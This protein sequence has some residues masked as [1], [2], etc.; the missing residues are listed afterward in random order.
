MTRLAVGAVAVVVLL[1]IAGCSTPLVGER[2][3]TETSTVTPAP[4]PGESTESEE[5]RQYPPGIAPEGVTDAAR[6][7]DA[8]DA[9]LANT[10][11]TVRLSSTREYANG[12][13]QTRY[14]RVLRV[15]APDRFHY[16]L[17]V[18]DAGRERRI[19][20]WR[21]GEEALAAV[22]ADGETTYRRLDAPQRPTLVTRSE[23]ARV[24]EIAP[25]RLAG[26][27]T[28][29]GTRLYRLA[30]G[31]ADVSGLSNVSYVALVDPRGLLVS[32]TV[33]YEVSERDRTRSVRV[34]AA[35]D[36]VGETTVERPRWY[37]EA[38]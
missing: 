16:V 12:S 33:T 3:P 31:P 36:A 29:N 37:D 23:L 6:L 14:D 28:R 17:S 10:S 15:A 20:R 21:A 26:T 22:T 18:Q 5:S 1:G 27:E 34:T 7:V 24:L 30:G 13:T 2:G 25:S 9:V 8:H 4:L 11:H 35:F 19:E 32:Y 38:V